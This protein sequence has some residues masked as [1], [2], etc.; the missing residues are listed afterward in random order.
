MAILRTSFPRQLE[1]T[2]EFQAQ[3][4]SESEL[5]ELHER[6]LGADM[7]VQ[8]RNV[9]GR[10]IEQISFAE[11]TWERFREFVQRIS[12]D[13]LVELSSTPLEKAELTTRLRLAA[14]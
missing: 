8:L 2:R 6:V 13:P 3:D 12:A 7:E 4:A 10:A 14:K 11:V 9:L 5:K 1:M